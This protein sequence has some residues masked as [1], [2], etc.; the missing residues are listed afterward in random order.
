M[1]A[2][3]TPTTRSVSPAPPVQQSLPSP[4][5]ASAA[6]PSI[7]ALDI[8]A[9]AAQERAALAAEAKLLEMLSEGASQA[10]AA[11][12][13]YGDTGTGKTRLLCTAIEYAWEEFHRISR[14]YTADLGGFGNKLLSLIRMGVAQVYNP[15]THVE[16]FETIEFC[17]LGYWP[18]K[19]ADPFTGYADPNVRLIPPRM[20]RWVV[21]CPNGHEIRTINDARQL[22][23]FQVVCPACNVLTTIQNWRTEEVTVR[24]AGFKHVGAYM[25]DS[26]TALQEGVLNDM[27]GRAGRDE[28]G[29]EKGAINKIVSGTLTLG[30]NNRAHYGFAQNRMY[31][32]IKNTRTIP[33]QV[34]PALFT[35][36]ERRATDDDKG[37]IPVYGPKIA[38]Q[39]KTTDVPSWVG[40]CLHVSQEKDE[41]GFD[42]HRLWLETHMNVNEGN[43]PHLAKTR[44]DQ[45][46]LLPRFL[47][48]PMND[49]GEPIDAFRVFSLGYF[50]RRL[51]TALEALTRK[52]AAQFADAPAFVPFDDDAEEEIDRKGL[53][54]GGAGATSGA[55]GASALVGTVGPGVA[56]RPSRVRPGRSVSAPAPAPVPAA[57]TSAAPAS[58]SPAPPIA[59]SVA[60]A[61]SEAPTGPT[62]PPATSSPTPAPA[63]PAATAGDAPVAPAPPAGLAVPAPVVAGSHAGP[64]QAAAGVP[65]VA[66]PGL[67]PTTAPVRP[68][69]PRPGVRPPTTTR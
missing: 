63:A 13:V 25:F 20:R 58:T 61:P 44:V 40:N 46:G 54:T 57:A 17:S 4:G 64:A 21:R 19:V 6:P 8:D 43:V 41:R 60:P 42:V 38:G 12:A 66:A 2:R 27:S 1:S 9:S 5:I 62:A 23:Q 26:G 18:E 33:G 29:G 56:A 69:R 67:P 39:A 48:D 31:Q 65:P 32:W 53:G 22:Y 30:S 51:D 37:G 10:N 24:S 15:L 55:A 50:F 3:P 36:L 16:P 34:I 59:Q 14:V 11:T 45:P 28:L 7:A 47:Q 35:F 52:D 49:K 68:S